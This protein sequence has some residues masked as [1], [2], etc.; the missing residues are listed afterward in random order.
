MT[1]PNE[2]RAAYAVDVVFCLDCT[3]SM[4]SYLDSAKAAARTFHELLEAKMASKDKAV[5]QLRVRI[6]GYRDLGSEGPDAIWASGF[7]RLPAE[8][9]AFEHTLGQLQASG[10]GD[11]PESALEALAV[12][13]RSPWERHL[14]KRR[15]VVVVC[16][17]ASAHPLG[18]FEMGPV[19]GRP[20]PRSLPELQAMW[21]DQTDEGEMEYAAKRLLVFG[22]L[23]YPWDQ[24]NNLFE[25][26]IWFESVAGQGMSERDQDAVLE[27]IAGSV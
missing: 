19:D 12:A 5:S 3:G 26:T 10:G 8:T 20:A 2:L 13:I 9:G 14:D 21:G 1:S 16:T 22:P 25:N 15:H 17:D 4:R 23:A 7:F 11:E 6:V 18:R 27:A 24:I